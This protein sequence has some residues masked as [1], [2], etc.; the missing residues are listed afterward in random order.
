MSISALLRP[1]RFSFFIGFSSSVFSLFL[2]E[3]EDLSGDNSSTSMSSSVSCCCFLFFFASAT[4]V[5]A[6]LLFIFLAVGTAFHSASVVSSVVE[7]LPPVALPAAPW[8]V[9][10]TSVGHPSAGTR[11]LML[12]FVP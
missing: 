10:A 8:V 4:F 6:C 1:V 7:A 11:S 2:F 3:D 9:V 12:T 5:V